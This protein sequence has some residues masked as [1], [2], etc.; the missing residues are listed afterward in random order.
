MTTPI[1]IDRPRVRSLLAATWLCTAWLLLLA[2][3]GCALFG[4][5]DQLRLQA[6]ELPLDEWHE[7][8]LHCKR[9]LCSNW[10]KLV[11]QQA[12]ELEIEANAP[13]HESLPDFALVVEDAE[14]RRIGDDLAPLHRPRRVKRSFQPGVYYL[15]LMGLDRNSELMSY[16]LIVRQPPPPRIALPTAPRRAA[17]PV[18]KPPPPKTIESAVIE[19]ERQGGE[20]AFV[21]IEAGRAA[22]MAKGLT[23]DLVDQGNPI[24][25]VEIV[26]VYEA[27]SRARIVG[28]LSAPITLDTL[29]RIRKP[30]SGP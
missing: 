25:R 6:P 5:A 26:D 11:V 17:P 18:A 29:A 15:Q 20:P 30:V 3:P 19:V 7:G 24:G 22:G 21:L 12:M 2:A 8:S 13:V 27:G 28:G 1:P 23:G 16:K 14:R 10:Y 9:G 4:G